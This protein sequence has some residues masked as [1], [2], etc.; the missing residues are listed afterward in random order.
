MAC[1]GS[2][3]DEEGRFHLPSGLIVDAD[4]YLYVCDYHKFNVGYNCFSY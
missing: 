2:K 1:F 3:G 4:G